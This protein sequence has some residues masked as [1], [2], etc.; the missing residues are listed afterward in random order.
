[1]VVRQKPL[2]RQQLR[3]VPGL[4]FNASMQLRVEIPECMGGYG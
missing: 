3:V 1:M 2:D 4:E